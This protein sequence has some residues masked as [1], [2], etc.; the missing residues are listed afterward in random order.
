MKKKRGVKDE[1]QLTSKQKEMIQLQLE[2]EAAVRK[3]LLEVRERERGCQTGSDVA[4]SSCTDLWWCG[5]GVVVVPQ[6]DMELLSVVC[7][8]EAAL[9]QRP[10][11]MSRELPAILQVL[12]PL[13]HSPLAAPRIQQ[14]FLHAGHCLM[15]KQLQPLGRRPLL[16]PGQWVNGVTP[17]SPQHH[18]L[19]LAISLSPRS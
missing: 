9:S 1:V 7:L 17:P 8:L 10:P 3:R 16:V 11:Q 19:S 13:L 14:V 2:K 18:S 15:P 5:G 4:S 12:M 6:L